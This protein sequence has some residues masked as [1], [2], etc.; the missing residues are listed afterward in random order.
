M[1]HSTI[2]L[3][4]AVNLVLVGQVHAQESQ[5]PAELRISEENDFFNP[6][7][8]QTDRYYTQGLRIEWLSADDRAA[9]RFLPGIDHQAWCS[10]ICGKGAGEGRVQTGFAIGQNIYTPSVIAVAGRQP[11]D[12][13]WGG[14][15]YASRIARISYAEPALKAQRQDRIEVSAGIVGPASL[16]KEA[17][18][19]WHKIIGVGLPRGWA[20]QLK[21]EPVVQLRYET[22]LRWPQSE[23]GNADVIARTRLNLGNA[24]TSLE[25]EIVGRIGWGLSGFGTPLIPMS[26]PMAA[27]AADHA[28]SLAG[29]RG[30]S[31]N[32][33]V[34]AG[35]KAVAHNIFLD[36]NT[37]ASNDIR[38]DRKL[39]VPEIGFGAEL[40]IAGRLGLTF[41]FV[42]RGS[43]FRSWRGRDGMA[44]DFGSI[45][46]VWKHRR[47]R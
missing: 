1:R 40:D 26:A 46:L 13:P 23:G 44:Q 45:T 14:M 17:Q 38:I 28:S 41:Q 7:T 8:Q 12:H 34:R 3:G 29:N 10:M 4:L 33:F 2:A 11:Y 24:L 37:F 36:G 19:E 21:N 35:T 27:T 43:E 20:N 6:L 15:L 25:T 42:R 32:L 31:A 9:R 39:F 5:A 18:T 16:A 22:A 30:V 47:R